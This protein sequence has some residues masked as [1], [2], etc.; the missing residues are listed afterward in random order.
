MRLSPLLAFLLA[1]PPAAFAASDCVAFGSQ[2]CWYAGTGANQSGSATVLVY[3]RGHWGDYKGNVP[4]GTRLASARQAF[5]AYELKRAADENKVVVLVTGS[6]DVSVSEEDLD[7]LAEAAKVKF[8]GRW[9]A[10]HS[11]GFVGLGASLKKLGPVNRVVLLDT[12]YFGE[13]LSKLVAARVAAGAVCTGFLTPHNKDRWSKRFVPFVA[14]KACPVNLYTA[15]SE[16]EDA[17]R[18]CLSPYLSRTTCL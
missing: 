2:S 13:D 17:V 10:S 4:A 7:K 15:H 5:S 14:E 6:S 16:H 12:F 1:F 3:F 8:T 9:L 18:R 11:G